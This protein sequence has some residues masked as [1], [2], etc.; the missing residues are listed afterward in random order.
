MVCQ[1]MGIKLCATTGVQL[2]NVSRGPVVDS[3]EP[4]RPA[5]QGHRSP[6]NE[7]QLGKIHGLKIVWT[8]E[9]CLCGTKGM[10]TT[11]NEL[12]LRRLPSF[13]QSEP[14]ASIN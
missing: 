2:R 5:Y 11:I 10:S 9:I 8:M 4:A 7:L 12:Q 14:K 1:A 3:E 6:E 13:L